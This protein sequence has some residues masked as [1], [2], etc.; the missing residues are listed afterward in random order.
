M[1]SSKDLL[2]EIQSTQQKSLECERRLLQKGNELVAKQ[3]QLLALE[4]ESLSATKTTMRLV[5]F[6]RDVLTLKQETESLATLDV[7]LKEKVADLQKELSISLIFENELPKYRQSEAAYLDVLAQVRTL[8]EGIRKS[9]G[10][11]LSLTGNIKS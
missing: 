11:L 2:Q 6:R 8:T 1:K 9:M 5:H 3:K 7:S 10:K 4:A